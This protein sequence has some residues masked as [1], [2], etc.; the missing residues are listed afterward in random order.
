MKALHRKLLREIVQLRGQVMAIALVMAG[1]IGTMVMALGNHEALSRTRAQ[2]YAEYGFAD[3][4]AQAKRVPMPLANTIR[5]VPGVRALDARIVGFAPLELDGFSD[6]VNAQLV[7]LPARGGSDLNR[8]HLRSGRLPQ[9]PEET[10]VGEAFAE[11]H[12]LHEGDSLVAILNGRRQQLRIAGIGLSPEFIYQIKPGEVFPDFQRFAVLWMQHEA[13]DRA[14]DMDGAFNNLVAVLQPGAREADVID[15]I[16]RLLAPFGGTGATGRDLQPSHRFLDEE[17][18]QLRMMARM[19]TAIFLGVT[20]F[21]LNVVLGR[22]V[23]SQREQI[24][25]LKAFGYSRLQVATHYAQLVLMVVTAGILPG[26][27]LGAWMGRA[28]AGI[29]REYYRFPYLEWSLDPSLVL[30]AAAFAIGAGTLGTFAALVRVHR[31]APAEAMRPEAPATFRPL[32]LERLGLGRWVDPVARMVLRNLERR[33]LRTLF[34]VLGIGLA[35]GILVMSRAMPSSVEHIVDVQFGF[36]QRDDFGIGFTEPTGNRAVEELARLP[37]VRAV[38]PFRVAAVTLRNGHRSYRTALQGLP[39][40]GDLKRVLDAG[41]QP[42]ALPAEGL[43]LTDYL[44]D[45]LGARPGDHLQVQFL[46]GHRRTITVPVAGTVQEFLGVGAYARHAYLNTLLTDGNVASGAWL[47][48]DARQREA[49]LAELRRRPRVASVT[50]RTAMIQSFRDTMAQSLSTFTFAITL[51]AGA[52]AAGVVYNAARITLAERGRELASLRVLGYTREEVRGF[53]LGELATLSF[54]ALLPGFALGMGMI[55]LLSRGLQS[56]L[57]RIPVVADAAGLAFAGL[58]VL[59]ATVLSA[60]MVRRRLDGLD[61][62][63][64]LKTKE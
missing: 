14:F 25:L 37:G 64:A 33:P 56:D 45:L 6:P 51:M 12:G 18:D 63:A 42:A 62:V 47:A 28:I 19:F 13:M 39:E 5:A 27:A 55:V 24:A 2:F 59:A 46:E 58:V 21:L 7:S 41:I 32:L 3:V 49:V 48:I 8:L 50:D 31:L 43:L 36:A 38:E 61:L 40:K 29:Y 15:A 9:R 52:I 34:S 57:F 17:L 35:C 22:L 10:V 30:M 26:L 16:D 60:L 4:F 53:L 11:A 20:A 23:A 1:G 54:M 44:A